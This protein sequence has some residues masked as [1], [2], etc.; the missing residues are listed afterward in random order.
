M[1]MDNFPSTATDFHY[2][3]GDFAETLSDQL[4][5]KEFKK[6]EAAGMDT[7]LLDALVGREEGKPRVLTMIAELFVEDV[8]ESYKDY[9]DSPPENIYFHASNFISFMGALQYTIM[10]IIGIL[11]KKHNAQGLS[12]CDLSPMTD[13]FARILAPVDEDV[14]DEE[15]Y[16]QNLLQEA[17]DDEVEN[18]PAEDVELDLEDGNL[19]EDIEQN[20]RMEVLAKIKLPTKEI[21]LIV[22]SEQYLQL[23][24]QKPVSSKTVSV[25][26]EKGGSSYRAV[27]QSKIVLSDQITR[28]VYFLMKPASRS[29]AVPY[30]RTFSENKPLN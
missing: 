1:K 23:L 13:F 10:E 26:S 6:V 22:T 29:S 2:D 14:E 5:M 7:A 4:K 19:M 18:D 27:D 24:N 3:G 28:S 11:I 30:R 17:G 20:D 9:I 15:E 25:K 12:D 8:I 16:E 21:I